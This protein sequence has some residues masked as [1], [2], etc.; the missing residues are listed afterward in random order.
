MPT[1][2]D[3]TTGTI[4]LLLTDPKDGATYAGTPEGLAP[5]TDGV[6]KSPTGKVTKANGFTILNAREVNARSADLSALAV[7]TEGGG[8]KTS[9]L[10]EAFVGKAS[11]QYD[12]AADRTVSYTHLDAY[13]RQPCCSP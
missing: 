1:G 13:K 4:T 8:I 12:A 11:M 5:L 3:V 6:E 2:A 9:G 10:S 7:P